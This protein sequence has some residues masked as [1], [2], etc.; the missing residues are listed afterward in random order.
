M[1]SPRLDFFQQFIT[2]NKIING[3]M[4]YS[5]RNTSFNMGTGDI[6]FTY[7]L[8]RWGYDHF[9]TTGTTTVSQVTSTIPNNTTPNVLRIEVTAADTMANATDYMFIEQRIEGQWALDLKNKTAIWQKK[10]RS[11]K[12]GT[13]VFGLGDNNNNVFLKEFEITSSGTW[14]ELR[15]EVPIDYFGNEDNSTGLRAYIMLSA[16]S[17]RT[18]GTDGIWNNGT[19]VNTMTTSNQ[20]NFADTIGNYFEMG[21]VVLYDKDFGDASNNSIRFVRAGRNFIEE[22][23]LCERYYETNTYRASLNQGGIQ[24]RNSIPYL[25]PKRTIPTV[26]ASNYTGTTGL[27]GYII[28]IKEFSYLGAGAEP[29]LS[30]DWYADSEL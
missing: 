17:D 16:G 30:F 18:G 20:V 19:P 23:T 4:D 9:T 22:F 29:N 13:Y 12:T 11:N 10:V 24:D 1:S 6:N 26:T 14:T 21:E 27:G 8:D 28:G 25:T 15:V 5:Q 2:I 7:T 3:G